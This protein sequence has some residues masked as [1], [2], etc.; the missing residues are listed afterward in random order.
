LT[1][2][3][4]C[5]TVCT[6]KYIPACR[7]WVLADLLFR[8][9]NNGFGYLHQS[10]RSGKFDYELSRRV[11]E[12]AVL[13][14]KNAKYV[15]PMTPGSPPPDDVPDD[16]RFVLESGMAANLAAL[17]DPVLV[18][19]GFR[20]VRV[21]MSGGEGPVLQIMAERPDGTCSI[22]DCATISRQLSPV[23]D[24]YDPLPGAYRL[25][26]SSPGIDRP[27][28]RPSDFEDW[29]GYEAKI[30]LNQPVNGR[31]RFRGIIDGFEDGEVRLECQLDKVGLQILGFPMGMIGD[32]KL[33]LTDELISETLRRTKKL[34]QGLAPMDGHELSDAEVRDMQANVPEGERSEHPS[35]KPVKKAKVPRPYEHKPKVKPAKA[36]GKDQIGKDQ[37]S[38]DKASKH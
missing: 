10:R 38:K 32:A 9:W 6:L 29:A 17:I 26:V 14:T 22:D 2:T 15:E 4:I 21:S 19:L 8:L 12:Q 20:L 13:M 18:D 11:A 27:L 28:V 30:E 1:V 5:G 31:K 36:A 24:A 37:A 16:A 25:E 23:L 35:G 7:G 33:V 3:L 34:Q